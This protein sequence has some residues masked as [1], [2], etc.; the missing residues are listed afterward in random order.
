MRKEIKRGGGR[1]RK[2][3][4]GNRVI[5]AY[6]RKGRII[7]CYRKYYTN[8]QTFVYLVRFSRWES[9]EYTSNQLTKR[10]Y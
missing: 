10:T 6:A 9:R 2:F 4:V 8:S 3:V 7:D 5:T 1:P